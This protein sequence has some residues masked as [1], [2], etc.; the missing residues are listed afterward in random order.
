MCDAME[1]N[2]R[3]RKTTCPRNN[4]LKAITCR[5]FKKTRQHILVFDVI[6]VY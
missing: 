5:Y 6:N 4:I 2:H 3:K 1:E